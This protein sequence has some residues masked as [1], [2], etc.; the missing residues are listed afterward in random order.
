MGKRVL[1]GMSG[2]V[3]SSVSAVILK[4]QGYEVIGA[5]MKLH[6]CIDENNNE[7]NSYIDDAKKVCEQ[8][9]IE[10]HVIDLKEEFNKY[11]IQNFIESYKNATTPNPC[12][13]CNKYL[14]F[15]EFYKKAIELNCDYI[16]TGHYVKVEYSEKYEQYVLKM[17]DERNKDQSYF[18]YGISK[19]ILPKLI[20][21][22]KNINNKNDARIIAK[23]NML[24]VAEKKE[25]QEI[26]FIDNNDY[27]SFLE[28]NMDKLPKKGNIVLKTGEVVGK[29]RGLIYYTIGQ[30][31]GLGISYKY[32]L[33]VVDIDSKNNQV[34]VGEEKDLY[35][36]KLSADNVNFLLNIDKTNPIKVKAKVRFRAEPKEAILII[37]DEYVE[38]E[39]E[40]PQRAITPGQS[41]V[42]YVDDDI[43]LGGGTIR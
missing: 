38:V 39:F 16:A 4:E 32:P 28:K 9:N 36:N 20:F 41:V 37:K 12:V 14:K 25:S 13:Q 7:I 18:L 30:R 42:F 6:N 15:G 40:E 27:G 8:L 17:A 3:D 43:V 22:L 1:L 33:Y 2:G 26:C 29:H 23:E 35:K 11:V 34:I 19:E 5:T 24:Q 10:H 21:P 31:K